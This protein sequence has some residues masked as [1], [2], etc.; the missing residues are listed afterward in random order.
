MTKVRQIKKKLRED[1]ST[2]FFKLDMS[3][4]K[5]CKSY[6]SSKSHNRNDSNNRMNP[7]GTKKK[8]HMKETMHLQHISEFLT[9]SL[10]E[11]WHAV[12]WDFFRAVCK[13]SVVNTLKWRPKNNPAGDTY[14]ATCPTRFTKFGR[15]A[16][17]FL[18]SWF[19][20]HRRS[21]YGKTVIHEQNL[22]G[23]CAINKG[24]TIVIYPI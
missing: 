24:Y 20:F 10:G 4:Y 23:C 21:S 17:T 9:F 11:F 18:R 22:N 8:Q 6:H 12:C 16:S 19:K 5:L 3:S 15:A 14:V 1:G 13:T 2:N 7:F